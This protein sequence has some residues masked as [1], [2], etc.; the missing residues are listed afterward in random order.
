MVSN[1]A[2]SMAFSIS[3]MTLDLLGDVMVQLTQQANERARRSCDMSTK[4]LH[5]QSRK[6]EAV[7]VGPSTKVSSLPP[8]RL[9]AIYANIT[10][11]VQIVQ[12]ST[13]KID[14]WLS[15][16]EPIFTG[17]CTL[18]FLIRS[19]LIYMGRIELD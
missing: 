1:Y 10:Q 14:F 13:L 19:N 16:L 9:L 12:I 4:Q 17:L 5:N 15:F 6:K 8:G 2:V 11:C 18:F 7:L 3:A